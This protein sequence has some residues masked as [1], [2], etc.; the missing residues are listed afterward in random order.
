MKSKKCCLCGND[1]DMKQIKEDAP[2]NVV[3]A[4][5]INE[6]SKPYTDFAAFKMGVIDEFGGMKKKPLTLDERNSYTP[7]D[8]YVL[9]IKRMLG[10]KLDLL[11]GSLYM[12]MTLHEDIQTFVKE[13]EVETKMKIASKKFKEAIDLATS[14]NLP[15][16]VLEK[17][18]VES[19]MSH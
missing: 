4:Y 19:F 10:T 3:T 7:L 17:L 12:G 6:I 1:P 11:N 16:P 5:L 8:Q 9:R 14:L 15:K 18:I 2:K 13:K